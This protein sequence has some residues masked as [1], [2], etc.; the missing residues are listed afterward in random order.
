MIQHFYDFFL[1]KIKIQCKNL[2]RKKKVLT[3]KAEVCHNI[4]CS[5]IKKE[6]KKDS[7]NYEKLINETLVAFNFY[8][9]FF[10]MSLLAH[11]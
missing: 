2:S 7:K 5:L 1:Y 10:I 4:V 9:F 6:E 11:L 3:L 8:L